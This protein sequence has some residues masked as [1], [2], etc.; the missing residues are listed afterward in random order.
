MKKTCPPPFLFLAAP[1]VLGGGDEY[2]QHCNEVSTLADAYLQNF[3]RVGK[4]VGSED[5][6]LQNAMTLRC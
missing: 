6:C 1:V 2:K 4:H 3:L 5:S